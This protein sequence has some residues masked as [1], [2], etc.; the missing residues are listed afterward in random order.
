MRLVGVLAVLVLLIHLLW[1][2]WVILGWL[3]TRNRR[4][5]ASLHIGSLLWG[6]LMEVGPW[7][8]P[9]TIAEQWP[10]RRAG[11][12]AYE[13]SFLIHYLEAVIY[14]DV[15]QELLTWVG[16]GVCF[17]ILGIHGRRFWQERVCALSTRRTTR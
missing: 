13:G 7:P 11:S 2:L 10:Q 6:I 3:V 4:L 9:L 1:I 5:L 16:S 8:C 12:I 15:S 14:P 17:V